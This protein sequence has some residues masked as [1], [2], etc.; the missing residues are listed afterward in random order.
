MKSIKGK[1]VIVTGASSGLGRATALQFAREGAR[2]IIAARRE[3][4]LQEVCDAIAALGGDCKVI[5]TDVTVEDQVRRLFIVGEEAFG[6]ISVV[7]NNAGR[8]LRSALIDIDF[9][10]WQ[11]VLHGNLTSVYLCTRMAAESMIKAGTR[12]HI[13]TVGSIA[14]LFAAPNYSAYTAAKH[15]VT[16]FHRSV[17]WE[18]RK[19]GIKSSIIYPARI[20]T[21]FFDR[22]PKRPGR[23]QML[24]ANDVARYIVAIASR[25]FWRYLVVRL[26]LFF[27]RIYYPLRYAFTK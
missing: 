25:S 22:Y 16:G 24:S 18:L 11:S 26:Q 21:D 17:K 1:V 3:D 2:L 8:G 12:G 5:P 10:E 14:G 13:I 4:K 6:P 7:V 20:D 19:A 27:L 15:G 9:D 23:G